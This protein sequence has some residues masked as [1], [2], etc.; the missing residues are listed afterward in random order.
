MPA[1]RVRIMSR[2]S[3][4]ASGFG[5]TRSVSTVSWRGRSSRTG[6]SEER[7]TLAASSSRWW[8]R[9]NYARVT[10]IRRAISARSLTS[11]RH[12]RICESPRT[13]T[14]VRAEARG[15]ECGGRAHSQNSNA[16][17]CTTL[18]RSMV[19]GAG[20]CYADR[21]ATKT[22][23][24]LDWE[25]VVLTPPRRRQ[26]NPGWARFFPILSARNTTLG[27]TGACVRWGG[28]PRP[29]ERTKGWGMAARTARGRRVL[30]LTVAGTL[31]RRPRRRCPSNRAGER[32]R[33][34][35]ARCR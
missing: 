28:E 3:S 21:S 2:G 26:D 6:T 16:S 1:V 5:I 20:A 15:P 33:C 7:K 24:A 10:T 11:T 34:C 25:G 23:P 22:R 30:W 12:S 9:A 4:C 8:T 14:R 19:H 35:P 17:V 27:M 32:G 31:G 29:I 13:S 18:R